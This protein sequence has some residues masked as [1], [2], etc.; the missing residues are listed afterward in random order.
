MRRPV[1]VVNASGEVSGAE[2]VLLR[3]L[4]HAASLD[5]PPEPLIVAAPAGPLHDLLPAGVTAIELPLDRTGVPI[6]VSWRAS[7]RVAGLA[8]W[9]GRSPANA[10]ALAAVIADHPDADV[11]VNSLTA[12]PTVAWAVRHDRSRRVAWLVHDVITTLFHRTMVQISRRHVSNVV[13]VSPAA[14]RPLTALGLTVE[15]RRNGVDWP[16]A[17]VEPTVG[18]PPIVG[19][20]SLVT[21]WKGHDVLLDAVARLPDVHLEIAGGHFPHDAAYVEHLR[22]RSV[23]PDLAGRV[24]FLGHRDDPLATMRGWDVFVSTSVAPEAGPMTVIE[25]LSIGL[26]VVAS[27]H[28]SPRD[29]LAEGRGVLVPPGDAHALA[30]GITAALADD[31]ERRRRADA[32]RRYVAEQFDLAMTVP[33]QFAAVFGA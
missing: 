13:A 2:I 3:L 15:V 7:R 25:A 19:A 20:L 23:E 8:G 14:A 26:P 21:P 24:R 18:D 30:R 22:R 6:N 27:D 16:V 4:E 28:G 32:G 9:V 17:P 29:D 10:R 31:D 5:E 33:E 1:L 11:V 12:L